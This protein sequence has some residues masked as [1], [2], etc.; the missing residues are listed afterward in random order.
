MRPASAHSQPIK[1]LDVQGQVIH[2]GSLNKTLAPGMR[3]GWM[4]AGR[5]QARVE[6]LKYSQSRFP[7][8]LGQIALARYMASSAYDRYLRRLQ[9]EMRTRR[10]TMSDCI[11]R[12]FG[13][14]VKVNPPEGGMFLWLELPAGTSAMQLGQ[15]ARRAHRAGAAVFQSAAHGPL[16]APERRHEHAAGHGRRH[17]YLGRADARAA[18]PAGTP[19]RTGALTGCAHQQAVWA[20]CRLFLGGN[21]PIPHSF[22]RHQPCLRI[23]GRALFR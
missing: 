10:Q 12:H 9:Q 7:D 8:E 16:C 20:S 4:S 3:V 14:Q 11:A 13:D 6:M 23:A 21:W 2:C 19:A 15:D 5:W 1:A 18:R 17:R 22:M